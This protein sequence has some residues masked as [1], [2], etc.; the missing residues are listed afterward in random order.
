MKFGLETT[1]N[2]GD[3]ENIRIS[4]SDCDTIED[5]QTQ[6]REL[7]RTMIQI[8]EIKS[9]LTVKSRIANMLR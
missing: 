9:G 2:T 7:A 6:L 8:Y 3:Y 1:I 5:A 4:V